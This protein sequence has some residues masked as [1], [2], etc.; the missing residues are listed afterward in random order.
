MLEWFI[1]IAIVHVPRG[2][3]AAQHQRREREGER[4]NADS[5]DVFILDPVVT[6]LIKR[7]LR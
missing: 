1:A 7:D 3:P 4:K 5:F 6:Y 2:I